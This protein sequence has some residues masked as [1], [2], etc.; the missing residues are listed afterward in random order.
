M[1]GPTEQF[2]D[3]SSFWQRIQRKQ[4]FNYMVLHC[5]G[6]HVS[7]KNRKRSGKIGLDDD[8]YY[9]TKQ[10]IQRQSSSRVSSLGNSL[11]SGKTQVLLSVYQH[12]HVGP[13]PEAGPPQSPKM[14]SANSRYY[15]K[16]S[17]QK[18]FFLHV[19]FTQK[20]PLSQRLSLSSHWPKL[21][22]MPIS[23]SITGR[24]SGLDYSRFV[25][26]KSEGDPNF[27]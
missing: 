26:L 10:E 6:Q 5:F 15:I 11:T 12:K 2:S 25:P 18:C 4:N 9:I 17:R 23:K 20:H 8:F 21:C 19:N 24:V 13:F 7:V 14:P 27:S 1:P 3:F 22:H 16:Q